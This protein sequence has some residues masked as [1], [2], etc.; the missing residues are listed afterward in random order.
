MKKFS[1]K[2]EKFICETCG[3]AVPKHPKSSRDHCPNCLFGK[4]VDINPGDRASNCKG[5]LAPIGLDIKGK[6]Q[7]I[8]YK[9][10]KCNRVVKCITA[11]D[12]SFE[13][14]VKLSKKVWRQ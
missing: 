3:Y 13:E 1:K 9:C 6:K 11:P 8:V 7:Q 10:K 2:N 12:D 5:I 4:H 14:L